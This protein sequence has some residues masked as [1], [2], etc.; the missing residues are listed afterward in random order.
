LALLFDY[1]RGWR[2]VSFAGVGVL[3]WHLLVLDIDLRCWQLLRCRFL[4][5]L[6][7]GINW[8]CWQVLRCCLPALV[9][10]VF[11]D[12]GVLSLLFDILVYCLV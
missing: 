12:V 1:C 2:W 9:L 8:R 3:R 11:A 5:L 6:V 4:V 7:P 10:E